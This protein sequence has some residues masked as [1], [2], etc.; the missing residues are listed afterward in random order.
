MKLVYASLLGGV[1]AGILDL[2][3]A[4]MTIG[5]R[6]TPVKGILQ[7][8]ASGAI[9][10][11]SFEGGYATAF[12]GFGVH[13][14]I[15]IVMAAVFVI[16]ASRLAQLVHRPL[17]WGALYGLATWAAMNYVIVPMS[18]APGWKL[19]SGQG[20]VEGVLASVFLVGVPIALSARHFLKRA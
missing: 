5:L 17:L 3:C 14:T 7:Y 4:F 20:L 11:S 18:R 2:F 10:P 15:A 8:I 1:V 13:F 19:P 6:G 12:L 16:A 9:G